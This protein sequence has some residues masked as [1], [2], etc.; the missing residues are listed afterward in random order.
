M[1]SGSVSAELPWRRKVW[2]SNDFKS[3][4]NQTYKQSKIKYV[5]KLSHL[6][7][8]FSAYL[9]L[10]FVLSLTLLVFIKLSFTLYFSLSVSLSL[11]LCS[12]LCHCLSLSLSRSCSCSCLC[13]CSLVLFLQNYHGGARSGIAMTSSQESTREQKW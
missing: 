10:I 4:I 11:C 6:L 12:C 1:F 8:S 5:T 3:G 9:L 2:N 13:S 7:D